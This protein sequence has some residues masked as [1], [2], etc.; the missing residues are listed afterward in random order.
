[1]PDELRLAATS[2]DDVWAEVGVPWQRVR[3]E[4]DDVRREIVAVGARTPKCR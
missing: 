2:W 4:N 3:F 1:M